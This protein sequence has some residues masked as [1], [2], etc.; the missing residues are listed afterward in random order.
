MNFTNDM[1]FE[2]I[3]QALTKV[4]DRKAATVMV[5]DDENGLVFLGKADLQIT[6]YCGKTEYE[7][8]PVYNAEIG[9]FDIYK[10]CLQVWP[11]MYGKK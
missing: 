11:D 4:K 7:L 3:K 10:A 2:T 8:L 6:I 1:K 5:T 9:D